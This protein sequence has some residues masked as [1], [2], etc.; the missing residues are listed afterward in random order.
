[1]GAY[2]SAN[3]TNLAYETSTDGNTLTYYVNQNGAGLRNGASTENAACAMKLQQILTHAGLTAKAYPEKNVVVK[4]AGYE[5][6]YG[7][8]FVYN[9]NTLSDEDDPQS[10]TYV[11]PYGVTVMGGY[12]GMSDDWS[13]DNRNP[14]NYRTVLSAINNSAT[15]EQE[16]NGYHTVTFGAKPSGW[17]DGDKTTIIDGLYLIDG[18]ATSQAGEGNPNTRGGG[19]IV[20]GGAH[21][22]NCVVMN[23]EAIEGGGLYLLPGATVSGTAVIECEATNGAGI[24]ADNTDADKD[25]RAHILSCTIA[26]NEASSTGGG[27]YMED[28]AV[29]SVNTVVFDNRAGSDKNVSGVV[30]QQF[31]DSKLATVFNITNKTNYY[32]FNNCFV[33]TQEMPS[34]FENR[35]LDGDK[36]LYFADD[37]YRLKDYSFLIKHGVKN[38][39]QTALVT[40]FNVATLDIQNI[41]RIQTGNAAERLDAGAFAYEGG[42]LPTDLFTRIFV[43]PTTN[44]TLPA[45]EDMGKY[46]GR[47]FY[48]SF[49]TLEDALGYI[50]S[51][52]SGDK[53]TDA[54]KFEILV[55]GGTYKPSYLRTTTVDVTHDQKLYSFVVPQGVSIY[56]GFD[57]TENYSSGGITSIPTTDGGRTVSNM[58]DITAILNARKYSDFNQNNILEPWELANQTILSGQI[59]AS[60]TAQNAYH[61]VFTDK[62]EATTVNPVVLDGLT[63][64]Y[65]QTDDKLSY[66]TKE[67]EQG[68]GGGIYSNGVTYSISRCR[69]LNNT[70]VRGG[71]VF[72]CNADLNFSGCILAGNK[73]V[74]NTA[75]D[76]GTN[77]L[78]SRGG[79]AYVSGI[80][81]IRV[82]Y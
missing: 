4:I 80:C 54:T 49:S 71:A 58:G 22:R 33:E 40:T 53:A 5:G 66:S 68:R 78:T 43:S 47:S 2:E 9:A 52:R 1:M 42:I 20:P 27:L 73:T 39:Y 63:V 18:K 77:K 36:S 16:V 74:E 50:R 24:Y 30:S 25:S 57:G 13:D 46:L 12:D 62:G 6:E 65:G 72:V 28:G 70:A 76:Q 21:V 14:K 35:M 61:V 7:K 64:M 51:M 15:L 81:R 23:C 10:Y 29:M 38:E 48:T 45:G 26:N 69:L 11:I 55:A 79:A 44:V 67:D 60:S 82:G 3:E 32:P 37:Y 19:A 75:T 41:D 17:T 34:D 59:N 56:G 8:I 31:E